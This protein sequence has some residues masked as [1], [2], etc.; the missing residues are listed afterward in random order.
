M[1]QMCH[2]VQRVL[3]VKPAKTNSSLNSKDRL[4]LPLAGGYPFDWHRRTWWCENAWAVLLTGP[5]VV[6][7]TLQQQGLQACSSLL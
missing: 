1:G 6:P 4:Q 2:W 5:E 7:C 3:P